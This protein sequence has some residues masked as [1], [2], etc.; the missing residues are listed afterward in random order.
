MQL[1]LRDQTLQFRITNTGVTIAE[2]FHR[3]IFKPFYRVPST[4]P[5]QFPGT[6]LG[7]ATV[8]HLVSL[9]GGSIQVE[10][11]NHQVGFQI[12]LPIG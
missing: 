10:S 11:G 6:G 8:R 7:L 5:Y 2:S 4:D 3:L 1:T 12:N 9:L